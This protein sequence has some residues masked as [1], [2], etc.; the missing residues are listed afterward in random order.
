M[1]NW[2]SIATA[3]TGLTI[4]GLGVIACTAQTHRVGQSTRVQFGV[5]RSAQEVQLTSNAA[6]G[7]IVG[8]MLGLASGAGGSS[9][10]ARNAI[11]G[12]SAGAALTGAAEGPR[13]GMQYTVALLDGSTT[14]IVTDQREIREGDCVA[15]E[16]VRDTANIRRTSNSYCDLTNQHAISSVAKHS[17]DD[18]VACQ[19]AKEELADASTME[20][21]DVA[22]RKIALLCNG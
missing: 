12:A 7:A 4:V 8:G 11:I 2:K 13:T 18:A 6:E 14:T 1:S 22:K 15:V 17:T 3:I 20:A 10:S 5:V 21:V 16:Q 19:R 9:R